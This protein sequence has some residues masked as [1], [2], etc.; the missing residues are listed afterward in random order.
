VG[1]A[2][3]DLWPLW[4]AGLTALGASFLTYKP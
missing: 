1:G 2:T 3:L 4:A